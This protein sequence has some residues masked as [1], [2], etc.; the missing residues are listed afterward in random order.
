MATRG[1]GR[2]GTAWTHS[3]GM[4]RLDGVENMTKRI[5]E[6]LAGMKIRGSGGLVRAA[7]HVLNDADH[8]TSPLVPEDKGF[9]RASGFQDAKVNKIG[10]PYVDLGYNKNYAAAVHEMMDSV[11]GKDINWTRPGSGPKFLEASLKRNAQIIVKII[12]TAI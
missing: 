12:A 7:K 9:L 5:N 2:S 8:G 10:D 4:F 11:S 1:I 6:V 3:G